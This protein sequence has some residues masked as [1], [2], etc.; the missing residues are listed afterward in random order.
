[1]PPTFEPESRWVKIFLYGFGTIK[2]NLEILEG[3][4][5]IRKFKISLKDFRIINKVQDEA[6]KYKYK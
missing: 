3:F 2:K 4:E 5:T 6:F 1:M